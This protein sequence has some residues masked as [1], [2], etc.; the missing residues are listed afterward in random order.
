VEAVAVA[1]YPNE[2]AQRAAFVCVQMEL[3]I[4]REFVRTF[5][6]MRFIVVAATS[7]VVLIS[8]AQMEPA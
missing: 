2:R 6:A 5:E 8:D 3:R 4:A 1:A 7:P